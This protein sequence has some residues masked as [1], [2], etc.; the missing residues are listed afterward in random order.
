MEVNDRRSCT[1]NSRHVHIRHFFV[2]DLG[3]K[4]QIKVLYCPT[5]KMLADFFTKPLQGELFRF[6]RSIIMGHT[7]IIDVLDHSVEMKERV[8][9]WRK[10]KI[11][12]ISN[13]DQRTDMDTVRTIN[14][15]NNNDADNILVKATSTNN[16]NNT[17]TYVKKSYSGP[18]YADIAK[19]AK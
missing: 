17:N 18:T 14:T 19:R 12:L 7:S 8:E 2:K 15:S 9:K 10:Y 11:D 16:K 3:D 4:K 13:V 6:F 5:T 1:G